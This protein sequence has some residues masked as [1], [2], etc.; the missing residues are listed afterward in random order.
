MT[1]TDISI[2]ATAALFM[3]HRLASPSRLLPDLIIIRH[4][5]YQ[6]LLFRKPILLTLIITLQRSVKNQSRQWQIIR[7]SGVVLP[8]S[9]GA[10]GLTAEIAAHA[11]VLGIYRPG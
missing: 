4:T 11:N 10:R 6:S 5:A 8:H 1:N 2:S 3:K 9:H 7:A